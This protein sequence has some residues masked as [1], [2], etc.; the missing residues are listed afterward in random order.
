MGSNLDGSFD[1]SKVLNLRV[2]GNE[3]YKM[4]VLNVH[5]LINISMS[6]TVKGNAGFQT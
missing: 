6:H 3:L 2:E 4:Q 1:F 5:G